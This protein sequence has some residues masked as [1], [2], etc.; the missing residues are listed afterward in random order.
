MRTDPHARSHA[1]GV[2]LVQVHS[3]GQDER[4]E[5]MWPLPP[6]AGFGLHEHE[7]VGMFL[8]QGTA[9]ICSL[10]VWLRV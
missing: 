6:A 4:K 9:G 5:W 2:D 3:C 8:E 10:A 1:I 7:L